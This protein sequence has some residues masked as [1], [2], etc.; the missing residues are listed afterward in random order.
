MHNL[1]D[2]SM[3]LN[4]AVGT[5]PPVFEVCQM[6]SMQTREFFIEFSLC[7][8]CFTQ[9][10][11]IAER[12]KLTPCTFDFYLKPAVFSKYFYLSSFQV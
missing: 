7:W 11:H 8:I 12:R 9:N 4:C 2:F 10:K 6:M 1:S 3:C 5:P